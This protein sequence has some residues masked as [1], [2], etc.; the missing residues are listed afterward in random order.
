MAEEFHVHFEVEVSNQV[1][2]PGTLASFARN[3]A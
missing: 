1:F 2:E 3:Q